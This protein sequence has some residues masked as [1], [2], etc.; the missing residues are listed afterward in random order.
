MLGILS[1]S[2]RSESD[3]SWPA[4]ASFRA[5]SNPTHSAVRFLALLMAVGAREQGVET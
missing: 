2:N 3:W 5:S 4:L 1:S